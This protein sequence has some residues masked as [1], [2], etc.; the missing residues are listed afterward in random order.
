MKIKV[1]IF[2]GG[3]SRERERSFQ[4]GRTI[5]FYLNQILFEPVPIFVTTN[6]R[7]VLLDWAHLNQNAIRDFFPPQ[8]S[9]LA[10]PNDFRVYVE[11]LGSLTPADEDRL[12]RRIGQPIA[13]DDLPQLINLAYLALP[14][15]D[16]S[17]VNLLASKRIPYTGSNDALSEL[18]ADQSSF[19]NFLREKGF[20]SP[21]NLMISKQDW[22]QADPSQFVRLATTT[23]GS[24]LRIRST[25]QSAAA[26][27]ITIGEGDGI[28]S[29]QEAL[30]AQLSRAFVSVGNWRKK[31]PFDRNDYVRLTGNARDG[32]GFPITV[33]FSGQQT[34]IAH[35]EYL[36]QFL[37]EKTAITTEDTATFLLEGSLAGKKVAI[38]ESL[39]GDAFHCLVLRNEDGSVIALPPLAVEDPVLGNE[40]EE[41]GLAE[42]TA[43]EASVIAEIC[44][45]TFAAIG[46][47]SY[48][49]IGG[50]LTADQKVYISNCYL[51]P[52]P[53]W[54]ETLFRQAGSIGL[55]PSQ[56]LTYFIRVSLW[57][58]TQENANELS[59][60]ALLNYLDDL[61]S[62]VHAEEDKKTTVAVLFGGYGLERNLSLVTG[63][64]VSGILAGSTEYHVLP[65]LLTCGKT[66]DY[67]FFQVP[68][69]WLFEKTIDQIVEKLSLVEKPLSLANL[70]TRTAAIALKYNTSGAITSPLPRTLEDLA[71]I[72]DQVFL[73][74][75]GRPGEDGELAQA[76]VAHKIP[77]N[78]PTAAIAKLTINKYQTAQ[79]LKRNGVP[80]PD[81]LLIQRKDYE[82][83]PQDWYQKIEARFSYPLV[84]KPNDHEGGF[85]V[86]MVQDRSELV[87]YLQL[88][89]RSSDSE[90]AAFRRT[91]RLKG[92]EEFPQR[93]EVLCEAIVNLHVSRN[94]L[95]VCAPVFIND[96]EEGVF[97]LE[98]FPLGT[99]TLGKNQLGLP[100]KLSANPQEHQNL[101]LQVKSDLEKVA[102]ILNLHG[103][104]TIDAFLQIFDDGSVETT[105][106]EVNTLP[107]LSFRGSI[108]QQAALQGY[109]PLQMIDKLLTYS[110]EYVN[111][112]AAVT[113][114]ENYS[115]ELQPLPL[116]SL[117]NAAV[118]TPTPVDLPQASP[119]ES[120]NSRLTDLPITGVNAAFRDWLQATFGF[121]IS[122]I[123]LRNLVAMVVFLFLLSLL[124]TTA[125]KW[126]THHGESVQVQDYRGVSFSEARRKARSGSFRVVV[127]DSSE[128]QPGKP[129]FLVLDQNPK[130]LSRVKESRN[131][132][133]TITA[134]HP[135]QVPLPD[136]VG[137]DEFEQYKRK[138]DRLGIY[139]KIKER[140]FDK[141]YEDNTILYLYYNGKK[142]TPE[143][144]QKGVNVP[145]GTTLQFAVSV[146][147]TG[148]M[149][150]P[151]LVCLTF[152]EAEFLLRSSQLVIGSVEGGNAGS[153]NGLFV[154]KQEPAFHPDSLIQA[155]RQVN[156]YLIN[157]KPDECDNDDEQ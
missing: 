23:V 157:K 15:E 156:L 125:L 94:F 16:G 149:P 74:L 92:K 116:P 13:V 91:L 51:H 30:D 6:G 151:N 31:S 115:D 77:F 95:E 110:R 25:E 127:I 141:Q 113:T 143:D 19:L 154:W 155:G 7:F 1:G 79:V 43:T 129:P 37:N 146:R 150:I 59:Y 17:I 89:F 71:R 139:A 58:R 75:H 101:M 102:R 63:R 26:R 48:A 72:T 118:F 80:I 121:F 100:V 153:F 11:S 18:T 78:G 132:Y 67:E 135:N 49:L 56:L 22:V 114:P 147:N 86:R 12:L 119:M 39:D 32:L 117:P 70:Q 96:S 106:I 134:S 5:Y 107:V 34:Q 93:D 3:G 104:C 41:E 44:E 124:G 46:A 137:S 69:F 64:T 10:S 131:I 81:Q 9:L 84:V 36:L 128:Y 62:N 57:E 140:K 50:Y 60:K 53:F 45:K 90:V 133:L 88:I 82:K 38:E 85:G 120:T 14:V 130:P 109:Q 97:E 144:L 54:L 4:A 83:N 33:T 145:K 111:V 35:P 68:Y 24:P 122:A 142:L 73:A 108:F 8:E 103:L 20:N 52:E 29:F 42:F 28:D 65:I 47:Q 61:I 138:L 136:L 123:F 21:R 66:T 87:A 152:E 105:V 40:L 112:N 55:Q 126:Y 27:Q 148:A 2:F 76:L 99:V 98:L